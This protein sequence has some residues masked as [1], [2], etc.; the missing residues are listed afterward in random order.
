[1]FI[2][3]KDDGSGGD[4]WNYESCNAL[5]KSSPPTSHRPTLYRPD[6][7][8]V[9]QPTVSK[10]WMEKYHIPWTCL[11]EAHLPTLF[12]TTSSSRLPWGRVAMPLIS[13]LMPV[14]AK[15]LLREGCSLCCRDAAVCVLGADVTLKDLNRS[16]CLHMAL[17]DHTT[18]DFSSFPKLRKSTP[19]DLDQ[20]PT[21]AKVRSAAFCW[22]RPSNRLGVHCSKRW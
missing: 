7:L 6:A 15:S 21:I 22:P 2:E 4:N 12:S 8:P 1:M 20:A 17:C 5:V 3:P 16:T 10:H 9:A 13:P 11:P 14:P 18:I 19:Q